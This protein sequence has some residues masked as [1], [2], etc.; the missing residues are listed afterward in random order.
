MY[1]QRLLPLLLPLCLNIMSSGRLSRPRQFLALFFRSRLA[2]L[3]V[4]SAVR[5]CLQKFSDLRSRNELSEVSLTGKIP[6]YLRVSNLQC[7]Y[8]ALLRDLTC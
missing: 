2:P 7:L 1:L 3:L 5:P 6:L 4:A 8:W